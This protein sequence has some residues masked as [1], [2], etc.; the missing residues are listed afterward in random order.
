M[1]NK[2]VYVFDYSEKETIIL[3]ITFK[4]LGVLHFYLRILENIGNHHVLMTF[5]ITLSINLDIIK[6]FELNYY[7][8][9]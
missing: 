1:S 3:Q 6:Y 7:F 2:Y 5:L 4:Y 9:Y 8:V